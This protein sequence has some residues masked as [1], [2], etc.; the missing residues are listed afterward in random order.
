MTGPRE[1]GPATFEGAGWIRRGCRFDAP[2]LVPELPSEVPFGFLG[3]VLPTSAP[4]ELR[5]RFHRIE[6]TAAVEML[7]AAHAVAEAELATGEGSTGRRPAQLVR[8]SESAQ[9][10][11]RQVAAREQELWRV[12][13][14]FHCLGTNRSRVERFRTELVR[15]LSVLGFRTRVPGYEVA[16]VTAAPD[17]AGTA[18]RP[19]GYWHTLHTDGV[20]AFFPFV[21]ET[22]A[23]PGGILLGLL[24][25]DASPVFLDRW[26]HA[27]QSWGVFGTTGSG[28]SFATALT[29]LRTRWMRPEVEVFILDPLGEFGGLAR[30]LG[31]SV[32][33]VAEGSDVRWN[34]LDPASTGGDRAEKAARVGSLLRALFPSL[35]DEEV[36]ALDAA[37]SRLYRAGPEVPRLSDLARE[38]RSRSSTPGRLNALFE[39]F[40]TGSLR[41][42]NG[43]T[44]ASWGSSPVSIDLSGVSDDHRPF[45]LAYLFD[46]VYGRIRANAG[47]KLLVV[48]EAHLL[49]G[50][51][52]TA[53]FFD[54]LVRHVRHYGAGVL[55]VSQNPDDFL[56][57]ESGRSLLRNLRATVLLRLPNV[58]VECREFFGLTEAE[59]E[60][61]PRARL[62]KEAGYSEGLLRFGEAH[63]P[64]AL[65]A[66]TPEYEFLTRALSPAGAVRGADLPPE[67]R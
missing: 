42:L 54:R 9:D 11:G 28:K 48:D 8:E 41:H 64:I 46:A 21:D 56:S 22:V 52:A 33:T 24:L 7:H 43:P 47:P 66:S 50:H 32:L 19:P 49:A 39:V 62:P 36:A 44:T 31:G 45:H 29:I 17:L 2:L 3:R 16:A 30:A 61:L 53:A 25:E 37:V 10:L 20:G 12:G 58:S 35:A 18:A 60:W 5:L 59:S 67:G 6:P 38:L 57:N 26:R 13:M 40:E 65:V 34:P 15:R 23:E 27:S 63:L 55:V 1:Q 4:I 51:P 14:S